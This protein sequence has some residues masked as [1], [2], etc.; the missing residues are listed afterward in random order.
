MSTRFVDVLWLPVNQPA[1]VSAIDMDYDALKIRFQ[2][3]ESRI[4]YCTDLL[5]TGVVPWEQSRCNWQ[6]LEEED[7]ESKKARF[8]EE[9]WRF[10]VVAFYD[11]YPYN[12]PPNQHVPGLCGLC[13]LQCEIVNDYT[14]DCCFL[15]MDKDDPAMMKSVN[16]GLEEM[17]KLFDPTEQLFQQQILNVVTGKP[18]NSHTTS[19][20]LRPD[21]N[22]TIR[23]AMIEQESM[24]DEPW[25][26]PLVR[27]LLLGTCD[28]KSNLY[29]LKDMHN[30]TEEIVRGWTWPERFMTTKFQL[31]FGNWM[32]VRTRVQED[33]L[34]RIERIRD[35]KKNITN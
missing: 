9:W 18:K 14:G 5:P 7:E 25:Q 21:E 23:Q 8:D 22:E 10:Q 17:R 2:Y 19:H 28:P 15:D 12:L 13:I 35:E 1:I 29:P 6:E 3:L 30:L 16:K 24:K 20:I 4:I 27:T 34:D 11:G 33:L 31:F 26:C 32:L